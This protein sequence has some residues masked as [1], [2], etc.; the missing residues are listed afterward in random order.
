V[1]PREVVMVW[2]PGLGR[3][4]V[5]VL[6]PEV[7]MLTEVSV[8]GIEVVV[9]PPDGVRTCETTGDEAREIEADPPAG[10]TYETEY[11]GWTDGEL[12]NE[13][14]GTMTVTPDSVT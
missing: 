14:V 13:E 7:S 12:T 8:T 9:V 2:V 6:P 4:T 11:S 10:V 3:C 1:A 5:A